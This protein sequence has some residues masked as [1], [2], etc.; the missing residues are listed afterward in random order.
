MKKLIGGIVTLGVIIGLAILA[1]E[2]VDEYRAVEAVQSGEIEVPEWHQVE[3]MRID[4]FPD[5]SETGIIVDTIR[6]TWWMRWKEGR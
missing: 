1:S 5:R 2:S 6:A 4:T 3:L